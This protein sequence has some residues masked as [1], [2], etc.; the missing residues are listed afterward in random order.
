MTLLTVF[1]R[2][3]AQAVT[4][5]SHRYS[6]FRSQFNS[7]INFEKLTDA[8]ITIEISPMDCRRSSNEHF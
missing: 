7:C 2:Y 6:M 1:I 3:S 5:I 4:L 8:E